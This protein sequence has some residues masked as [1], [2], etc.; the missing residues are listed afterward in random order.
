MKMRGQLLQVNRVQ[1]M[2]S[3]FAF[4]TPLKVNIS[5]YEQDFNER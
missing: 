4:N 2:L 5:E 3:I 1:S